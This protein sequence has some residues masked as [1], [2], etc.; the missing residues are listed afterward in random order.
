MLKAVYKAAR[1]SGQMSFEERMGCGFGA[2]MGCT[3]E[4]LNG[5]KRVCREGPVFRKEELPW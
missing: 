5:P 3:I 2:C 4:T 1:T